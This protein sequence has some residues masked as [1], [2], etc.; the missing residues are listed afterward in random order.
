MCVNYLLSAILDYLI[1]QLSSRQSG[2]IGDHLTKQGKGK[3][4]I[5]MT[6]AQMQHRQMWFLLVRRIESSSVT[7]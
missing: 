3:G 2:E 1:L 7:W 4:K 6:A 5:V